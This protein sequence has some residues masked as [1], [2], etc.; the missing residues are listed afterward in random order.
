M[1]GW[2]D[3][4]GAKNRIWCQTC[5]ELRPSSHVQL[6]KTSSNPPQWVYV[7]REGEDD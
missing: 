3:N 2:S 6:Q 4:G 5:G 7:C 1:S